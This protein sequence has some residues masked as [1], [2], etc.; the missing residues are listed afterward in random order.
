MFFEIALRMIAYTDTDWQVSFL[1]KNR[2]FFQRISL[3]LSP[4][5]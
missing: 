1:H 2:M 5:S 4:H 3:P